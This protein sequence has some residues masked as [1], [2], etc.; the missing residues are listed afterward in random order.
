MRQRIDVASSFYAESGTVPDTAFGLAIKKSSNMN[1]T[2]A[3]SA[4]M[5]VKGV[6]TG[7][8]WQCVY[9]SDHSSLL[10]VYKVC[11]EK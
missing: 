9:I 1:F 3:Y 2:L 8:Q 5:T 4:K 7:K 10:R 6:Q 11:N